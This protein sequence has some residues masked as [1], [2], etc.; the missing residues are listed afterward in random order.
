MVIIGERISL[1]DVEKVALCGEEVSISNKAIQAMRKCNKL[2]L[3][4]VLKGEKVYGVTTGF[5]K[6][7]D[8]NITKEESELLQHN[9]I[10]SHSCGTGQYLS[11]EE[12]RAMMLLR[13]HM[14]AQGY[15][16]VRVEVVE[17]LCRLLNDGVYPAIPSQGSV[18]ASGDLVPLAHLALVLIGEGTIIIDGK[19][20]PSSEYF[21]K[22]GIAPI[23]L[24]AKEGLSL[25]NGTQASTAIAVLATLKASKLSLIADLAGAITLDALKGSDKAFDEQITFVRPY[26]GAISTAKNLQ[27]LLYNSQIRKSHLE[28]S[29]IQDNYSIRCMPQVHGIVKDCIEFIKKMLEIEINSITDNPILFSE[30]NEIISGGNFHGEPIAVLMDLLSINMTELSNISERRLFLLT[31]DPYKILPPFLI[32]EAGLN[33]GFMM[34]Q[35]AAASL[36]SENKVLS[37]PACVDSIPTSANKEDYVS[38]SFHAARKA[39]TITDNTEKVLAFELLAGLQGIDFHKPLK[40]SPIIEKIRK[41]VRENI[42][43]LDKDRVIADDISTII[44]L[45]DNI[46]RRLINNYH[47][48]V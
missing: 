15:S 11:E 31:D 39:R 2:L 7:S 34:A 20:H 30:T 41:I 18:G 22:A 38:M 26:K 19:E 10:R 4:R 43:F 32:K 8:V 42:S 29:R 14:L 5:G 37:H 28:C 35:V 21:E 36:V 48:L 1:N 12:V 24:Q 44:H 23:R 46:Y 16:G 6:L 33:S 27:R 9:L 13:A 47:L 25:I 17:L 45:F 40:S 3:S